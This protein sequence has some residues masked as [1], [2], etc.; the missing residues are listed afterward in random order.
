M[1]SNKVIVKSIC[2][3]EGPSN[4]RRQSRHYSQSEARS[5][6][7]S[8]R[9]RDQ[10]SVYENIDLGNSSRTRFEPA[11]ISSHC[12]RFDPPKN[13]FVIGHSG[14]DPLKHCE[15]TLEATR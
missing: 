11:S 15:N 14:G 10:S 4:R 12:N 13:F 5:I 9:P 1:I 3:R 2:R 7:D 8:Q 6:G